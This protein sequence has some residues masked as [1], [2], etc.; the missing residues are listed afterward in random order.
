MTNYIYFDTNI[1]HHIFKRYHITDSDYKALVY[2]IQTREIIIFPSLLNIEEM[3]G[4]FEKYPH[5]ARKKIKLL[6][7]LVDFN[8]LIKPPDMLLRDDIVS[9]ACGNAMSQPFLVDP[10]LKANLLNFLTLN[11]ENIAEILSI[12]DEVKKQKAAFTEK[13][14]QA[15]EK[16][17]PVAMQLKHKVNGFTDYW[18]HSQLFA[19]D[20]AER[21]GVLDECKSR[22][23]EGLLNIKSVRLAVGSMLSYIYAQNFEGRTPK[24]GDSRDL[25]HAV[26]ASATNVFVIEDGGFERLVKRVPVESFEIIRLRGLLGMIC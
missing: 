21:A 9:Y 19:E 20:L 17:L 13:M 26:T 14:T 6:M 18:E 1:Y 25:Q 8:K 10:I 4:A 12:I 7:E 3:L 5:I 11:N 15:K 2:A 16:V 23:I 22:G 24:I